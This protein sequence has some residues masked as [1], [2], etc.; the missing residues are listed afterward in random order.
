MPLKA[1]LDLL[2][3]PHLAFSLPFA[4]VGALFASDLDLWRFTFITLAV[5]GLRSASLAYNDIADRDIDSKNPRTKNRPLVV[6]RATVKGAYITVMAF[7]ALFFLSSYLLN[8]YAFV[9]SP[10]VWL[11]ALSYPY[12]KRL[13]PLPHLHLGLVLGL[14]VF[15]GA[16]GA[17]GS[18]AG[19][20]SELFL[21]VPWAY[22]VAV[23]L[24]VAGFDIIYS[25]SDIEFDKSVGVKSLP[26]WL[27]RKGALFG[28]GLLLTLSI[29]GLFIAWTSYGLG[30]FS[31]FAI[32]SAAFLVAYEEYLGIKG[33]YLSA[34]KVNLIVA[35][36]VSLGFLLDILL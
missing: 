18:Q 15:G 32:L 22:V 1:Y 12:S 26:A 19:S 28:S 4:Y 17:Y 6:G 3:L 31:L 9:L 14:V 7:S 25:I 2:R 30:P 29:I 5:I 27:G 23:T 13:H 16:V 20:F 33:K 24:W 21:R 34:F 35:P 11:L 36:I 10:L 8:W